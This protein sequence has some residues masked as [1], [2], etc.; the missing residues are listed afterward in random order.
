MGDSFPAWLQLSMGNNVRRCY[1]E[2]SKV[3]HGHDAVELLAP[4][5]KMKTVGPLG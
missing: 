3:K 5:F 4:I 2:C 1:I